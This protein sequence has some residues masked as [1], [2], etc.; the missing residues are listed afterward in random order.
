MIAACL[1][2]GAVLLNWLPQWA[3]S[4]WS[5]FSSE[6]MFQWLGKH[7]ML[8]LPFSPIY[9]TGPV[10]IVLLAIILWGLFSPTRK[11]KALTERSS[12]PAP[13]DEP[14]QPTPSFQPT[15]PVQ[16]YRIS[17]IL[18]TIDFGR[19]VGANR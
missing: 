12:K 5:L 19:R 6:P 14:P 16:T 2:I 13:A 11:Q 9:I 1:G 18:H 8:R 15:I 3:A 7:H 4:V 17:L 10:S